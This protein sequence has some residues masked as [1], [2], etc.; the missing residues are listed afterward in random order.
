VHA[1]LHAFGV[2]VVTSPWQLFVGRVLV[3]APHMLQRACGVVPAVLRALCL[4]VLGMCVLCQCCD[5]A[6]HACVF[7]AQAAVLAVC[8]AAVSWLFLYLVCLLQRTRVS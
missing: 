8:V 5:H 6:C 2:L 4:G 7:F 1:P 3:L